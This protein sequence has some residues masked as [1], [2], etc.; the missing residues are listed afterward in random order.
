[1]PRRRKTNPRP[2]INYCSGH[3]AGA[4]MHHFTYR[5]GVLHGEDVNLIDLAAQ[6]GT[7]FYCYSS[8]TLERHYQVFEQAFSGL[9]ATIHYAIKANSNQAVI[10]TLARLGAGMDV[11]SG[12]ELARALAAGVEAEKIVFSGVGKSSAE[13]N[14]AFDAGVA[15]I[16]IESV[17]ELDLVA[18]IAASR[19]LNAHIA[20][21]INPDVD[22]G[23][24]AKITTGKAENKFGVAYHDARALYARAAGLDGVT[25]AG[26]AMH[27]GSQIT[28]LAPFRAAFALMADLTRDLRA[29]GHDIA[30]LDLGGGLGIPYRTGETP[31]TPADYA[32]LVG[33]VLGGLNVQ[34][35]LEPGRLITGN[36]GILVTRVLGIKNGDEKNFLIVDAAM[37]DLLRPTLYEAHHEIM[38]LR[39]TTGGPGATYDVV[40]P[41]CE[42]GDYLAL[43]RDL[44]PIST[45]DLIALTTAGAYGA[46]QAGT[47]NSRPLIAEIMVHGADMAVIRP[48]QT[49]EALIGLDRVPDWLQA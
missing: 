33:D 25:V 41:V 39:Q 46:V 1:M 28:D 3:W 47:Y 38:P 10:K 27:I 14:Q 2:W 30:H 45:G 21:R 40:G 6:V 5:G 4:L 37:N 9:D 13:I 34:L 26:I 7:P 48:R 17:H 24:H 15:H 23:T 11:V 16:N 20:L 18:Q 12:G 22:A 35:K 44:P 31:P 36:A 49:I 32:A 8:A 42:T 43:G 29:D 19:G